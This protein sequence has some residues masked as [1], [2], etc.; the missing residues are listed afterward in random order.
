[1][2]VGHFTY[3][4]ESLEIKTSSKTVE[5]FK[6]WMKWVIYYRINETFFVTMSFFWR[7]MR[8]DNNV[9]SYVGE[10]PTPIKRD[11]TSAFT[12]KTDF[13]CFL[14]TAS[15]PVT[16]WHPIIVSSSSIFFQTSSK[17]VRK[18]SSQT[19]VFSGLLTSNWI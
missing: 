18:F 8:H 16:F 13:H 19:Q 4:K 7:L 1:M 5:H 17:W 12:W 2:V 9:A 14:T 10:S 6:I 15:L 11:F 3:M